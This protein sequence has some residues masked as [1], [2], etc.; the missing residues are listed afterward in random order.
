MLLHGQRE[1]P[2]QRIIARCY[3]RLIIKPRE[4]DNEE[5]RLR[6]VGDNPR[7]WLMEKKSLKIIPL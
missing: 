2:L 5:I 3:V 1:G 7:N 4:I 6:Y